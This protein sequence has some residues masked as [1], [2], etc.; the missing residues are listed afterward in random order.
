V[1]EQL[2]ARSRKPYLG[3][4]Q[5]ADLLG[6]ISGDQQLHHSFRQQL[7]I[8]G[9]APAE[10]IAQRARVGLARGGCAFVDSTVGLRG[11]RDERVAVASQRTTQLEQGEA[12]DV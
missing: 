10:Y 3:A 7:P 11:H 9:T 8:E 2:I 5:P 12:L 4:P 6:L 1:D